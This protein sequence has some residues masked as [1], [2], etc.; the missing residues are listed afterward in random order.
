MTSLEAA[1]LAVSVAGIVLADLRW[2]RVAQREHYLAGAVARQAWR[3][4]R[5]AADNA[6]AVLLAAIAAGGSVFVPAAGLLTGLITIVAPFRLGLR[7]RTSSLTWTRRLGV[8]AA[9]TAAVEALATGLAAAGGGLRAAAPAAALTALLSPVAVDLALAATH[10]LEE[11]LAGSYVRQARERLSR[12]KPRVVGITGSYGKTTVKGY[13]A[14]LAGERHNVLVSPASFNNRAGLSR[15]VNELLGPATGVLVAEMG[16][17]GP[18]EIASLCSWLAPEISVITAIGPA[19]LERFGSLERTLAAKAEI[20]S[21]AR[22]A[23]LNIDDERLSGLAAKLRRSGRTV[24]GASGRD[25]AAEVAVVAADGGLELFVAGRRVGLAPVSKADLPTAT[26][27]AACAA[28][29]ALELGVPEAEVLSRLSSLPVAPNRLQPYGAEEGYLVLDD[30]FNSNPSGARLALARLLCSPPGAGS[31]R[32]AVVTPG[33]VELG[34]T[35][36]EENAAF[37]EEAAAAVDH[38]VVVGRTNRR[39]LLDGA[40]RAGRAEV[41]TVARR[42][43]AIT[44]VRRNLKQGDAVLY[45]NDLPDHY[46]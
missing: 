15:T 34:R 24:V 29:V 43:Q 10:P 25:P 30:T 12:V 33:M 1:A 21:G 31:G 36:H 13:V 8:L 28:A 2:L 23:V 6:V 18:G 3:W 39:A 22:V 26:S 4:W 20:T 32:R 37:A 7:G 5:S 38:L 16:A 27:N 41:V 14:H 17:Y 9:A 40:A 42:D 11:A 19:H 44:W 35:Q 45:E 46:P